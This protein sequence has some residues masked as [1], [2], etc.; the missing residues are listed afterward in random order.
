MRLSSAQRLLIAAAF[1]DQHN[2]PIATAI[3]FA[4]TAATALDVDDPANVIELAL[5]VTG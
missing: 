1:V 4:D 3:D 2:L 5:G